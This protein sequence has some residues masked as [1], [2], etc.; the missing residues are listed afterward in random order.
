MKASS[1][2]AIAAR[3]KLLLGVRPFGR[4][5]LAFPM[6]IPGL[7]SETP[8][9]AGAG[10]GTLRVSRAESVCLSSRLSRSEPRQEL[11]FPMGL[12]KRTSAAEAVK[13]AGLYGTAEAVP[14][15]QRRFFPQHV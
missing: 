12:E 8:R 13:Q 14:F 1:T 7:K 9:Q 6:R 4:T 3:L 5:R 10:W 2:Q 11:T 15:V